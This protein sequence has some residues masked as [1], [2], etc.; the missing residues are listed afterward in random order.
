LDPLVRVREAAA[1]GRV[2]ADVAELVASRF[3]LAAEGVARIERASGIA[4][5]VAYVDPTILVTGG[6]AQHGVLYARTIPLVAGSRLQVVIQVC[7]PLVAYGL[8]GTIHAILAHEFLHYIEL[9]RRVSRMDLVSDELTGN[10]FESV[11]ADESR[12]FRPGAVFSD[13]SLLSHITKRFPSGFRDYR[14]E[15]KVV[16]HWIDRGLPVTNVSLDSNVLKIPAESL[17]GIKFDPALLAKLDEAA[18]RG[19]RARPRG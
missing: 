3:K 17:A 6:G 8:K 4:Y 13:K 14:L 18:S 10:L 16:K 15:D 19:R 12:L 5:P 2:P 9:V 7:A 1:D 11:Y